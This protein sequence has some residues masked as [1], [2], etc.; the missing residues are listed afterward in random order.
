MKLRLLGL[1]SVV[2]A[3]VMATSADVFAAKA[4][5]EMYGMSPRMLTNLGVKMD[6][7]NW[8]PSSEVRNVARGTRVW[9]NATIDSGTASTYAWTIVSKPVGSATTLDSASKSITSF[10]PD[11]SG[12]YVIGV[13]VNAL[14]FS[15]TLWVG[16][17]AGV[18]TVTNTSFTAGTP[19]GTK[20]C[21][22]CHNSDGPGSVKVPGWATT[23]HAQRLKWDLTGKIISHGAPVND[24]SCEQ[25][26][27]TGYNTM[28]TAGG[29]FELWKANNFTNPDSSKHFVMYDTSGAMWNA[30]SDPMKQLGGITCE[31]CHGPALTGHN[32]AHLGANVSTKDGVCGQCHDNLPYQPNVKQ[33]MT[34][35]HG[36][37]PLT[38]EDNISSTTCM[39][40]HSGTGF[41][42]YVKIKTKGDTT[43]KYT[44][45]DAFQP[46][47]CA[48]CH[49]PHNG[50]N[51][52]RFLRIAKMDTLGNGWGIDFGGKGQLCMNCHRSRRGNAET[53]VLVVHK[54]RMNPHGNPQTDMLAGRNAVEYDSTVF[55]GVATHKHLEDACVDC[56]MQPAP[57]NAPNLLGGHS[58]KM[59][60]KDTA[61]VKTDNVGACKTCH[62]DIEDFDG[63]KASRDY[64][65]NGK[66]EGVQS[67]VRGLLAKVATAI[68][69]NGGAVD[70]TG[71]P[72]QDSVH[73]LTL[74][75][76][77]A[78]YN[79][80][81][82]KNDG[83]YG[84][85]NAKYAFNLLTAALNDLNGN[86]PFGGI[87]QS[88]GLPNGFALEG[89]YPNP[90]N[91][92]TTIR[93][94]IPQASDVR[95]TV[96][97]MSGATI[98]VLVADPLTAGRYEVTWDGTTGLG[99]PAGSGVYFC[100]LT[101][102]SY[103]ATTKMIMMK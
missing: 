57:S 19:S 37:L 92:T 8:T 24:A 44:A 45:S 12:F 98:K 89:N 95:L 87:A 9:M 20:Q 29:W 51:N 61:G 90:F 55:R 27:T 93:F 23:A 17:Y 15:D 101:A 30:L 2:A 85:H 38:N 82:V 31:A 39:Q 48:T 88:I 53:Y 78:I 36:L 68:A 73:Q 21:G 28:S 3:I 66:I 58:W 11:S 75:L 43:Q 96:Y 91:P 65:G 71:A 13:T 56:H 52:P 80:Y 103:S 46:I 49:D 10:V 79:W 100:R 5:W 81:F 62:G 32:K 14:T 94:S 40:C 47:N 22:N 50:N 83:S 7:K 42:K 70:T 99:T 25:C 41:I 74:K 60:G 26:H 63:I 33:W 18:G 54:D 34:S 86:G 1:L 69:A 59:S 35:G 102:G 67:E 64:D 72:M 97:D 77:K 76:R 4:K 16:T 6:W 84:V